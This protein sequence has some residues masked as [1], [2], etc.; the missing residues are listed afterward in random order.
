LTVLD[1]VDTTKAYTGKLVLA[2]ET[3]FLGGEA[4]FRAGFQFDQRTKTVD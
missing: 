1:A 3:E 2:R 4:T